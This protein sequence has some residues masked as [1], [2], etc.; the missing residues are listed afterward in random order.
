MESGKYILRI[1]YLNLTEDDEKIIYEF[2]S[3]TERKNTFHI[4]LEF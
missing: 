4:D 2:Y 1:N 3:E